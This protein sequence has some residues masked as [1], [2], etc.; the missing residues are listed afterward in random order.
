[1]E[2]RVRTVQSSRFSVTLPLSLLGAIL[3]PLSIQLTI[4]PKAAICVKSWPLKP[5]VDFFPFAF[6]KSDVSVPVHLLY[7]YPL[8]P[9]PLPADLPGCEQEYPPPSAISYF[10]NAPS[11]GLTSF[12]L[13]ANT[14]VS[15]VEQ[16]GF[17]P[18]RARTEP[19]A[20]TG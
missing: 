16:A 7:P 3:G 8:K 6:I 5:P 19:A 4:T 17:E 1:M 13:P 12:D 18:A 11:H 2:G 15:F 14:A 20:L 10:R 9:Y